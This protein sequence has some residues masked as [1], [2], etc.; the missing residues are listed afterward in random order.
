MSLIISLIGGL[1]FT[2]LPWAIGHHILKRD[3]NAGIALKSS[4]GW[5]IIYIITLGLAIGT[6]LNTTSLLFIFCFLFF[7]CL[8]TQIQGLQRLTSNL[9]RCFQKTTTFEKVILLFGLLLLL[10]R[11]FQSFSPTINWDSLNQ[12]LPLISSRLSQG[13]LSPIFTLPTDRRT[14]ISGVLLKIPAYCF[15]ENGR[16][17]SL[18]NFGIYLTILI[19]LWSSLNKLVSF[20]AAL[21]GVL[22]FL[23]WIDIATYFKHIGDEPLFCLF[24]MGLI[25]VI[26]EPTK[27]RLKLFFTFAILG[28]A[29]S[30]KL[31]T[32]FFIPILALVLFIRHIL[33]KDYLACT[34][35]VFIAL[36]IGLTPY[37]K[38]YQDYQMIYPIQRWTNL[39]EFGPKTPHV[40][41]FEE[42]KQFRTHYG[43]KNHRDNQKVNTDPL[44]K[45]KTNLK[46]LLYLPL[47]PYLGW[48]I[49]LSIFS[50]FILKHPNNESKKPLLFILLCAG[51]VFISLNL[52][53]LAWSFSAQAMTRYLLPI[54]CIWALVLGYVL[55]NLSEKTNSY[56]WV[57]LGLF[58]CCIFSFSLEFKYA[59]LNLKKSPWQDTRSYWLNHASDGPLIKEWEEQNPS[60]PATY[61][62]GNSSFLLNHSKHAVA[63]IGNEVGWRDADQFITYLKES[64]F[65]TFIYSYKAN[66]IDS[67]YD[68]LRKHAIKKGVLTLQKKHLLG[69]LYLIQH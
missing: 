69:E 1:I 30:I 21:I 28:L 38:Q 11:A 51:I 44:F 66:V 14:P 17:L 62:I 36:L 24:T 23:S 56:L 12:H 18:V 26:L 19:Q 48:I 27:S 20:K 22:C 43:I 29:F 39:L 58:I 35:G 33:L 25:S 67:Y 6:G 68:Y 60:K 8:K 31:T 65:E 42:I 10:I 54:W 63:Q 13:D 46:K 50:V 57:K 4:I 49:I 3:E 37:I 9:K 59:Y 47:G 7:I 15:G 55:Q 41:S 16:S 64:Q 52:A 61:Y 2:L 45:W 53:M 32:I 34:I 5:V 40:F